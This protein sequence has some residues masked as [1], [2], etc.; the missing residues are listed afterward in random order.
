MYL[1]ISDW[2]SWIQAI[3]AAVIVVL[4]GWTL[5]VLREYAAD[6]KKIADASVKQLQSSQMPFLAITMRTT[7][8]GA[9]AGWV[10]QN[11]GFG[12]AVN[13]RFTGYTGGNEPV[14]KSTPPIGVGEDRPLHN[15]IAQVLARWPFEVKYESLAGLPYKTTA[16]MTD[17]GL[18]TQFQ[19]TSV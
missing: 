17:I 14:L 8:P 7:A 6:T 4:T 15:D 2:P 9:P 18:Q 16:H 10:I 3:A 11:Q 5:K 13:I 1:S 12:P 19:K